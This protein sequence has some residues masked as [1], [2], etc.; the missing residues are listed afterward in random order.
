MEQACQHSI[1]SNNP[2]TDWQ[3]SE[4][5]GQGSEAEGQVSETDGQISE[6]EAESL[7]TPGQ[8][9]GNRAI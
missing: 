7:P 8:C 4:T 2:G 1:S 6:A 3:V 5:D 9:Q